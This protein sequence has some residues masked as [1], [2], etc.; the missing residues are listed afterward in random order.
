MQ[1]FFPVVAVYLLHLPAGKIHKNKSFNAS[2][3]LNTNNYVNLMKQYATS[4]K[5]FVFIYIQY[6]VHEYIYNPLSY[7][8]LS[9]NSVIFV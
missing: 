4:K 8:V 1:L 7:E 3:F 6:T 9:H 2:L 5:A